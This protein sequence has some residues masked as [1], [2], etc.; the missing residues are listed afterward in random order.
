MESEQ[1]A[2][3]AVFHDYL[4]GADD[5]LPSCIE[6]GNE[7]LTEAEAV[8]GLCDLCFELEP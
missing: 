7:L 3:E 8:E 4:M 5:E 1:S 6:C 2:P